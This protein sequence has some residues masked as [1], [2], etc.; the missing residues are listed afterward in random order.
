MIES[1]V[2]VG[3][4]DGEYILDLLHDTDDRGVSAYVATDIAQIGIAD[5]VTPPAVAYI[6]LQ[7]NDCLPELMSIA[8]RLT[9][10]VESQSHGTLATDAGQEREL[11][12]GS[13]QPLR[14]ILFVHSYA[15]IAYYELSPQMQRRQEKGS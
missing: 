10:Y 3:L 4:L 7:V 9:E 14:G 2:A 5:A 12:Y 8:G 13:L 15:K 6:A 11:V 1:V